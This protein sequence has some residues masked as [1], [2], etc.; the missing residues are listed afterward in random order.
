MELYIIR[1]GQSANNITMLRDPYDRGHY[2]PPL[3]DL[4]W[5]QAR[6]VADYVANHTNIDVW[7]ERPPEMREVMKG[8]GITRLYCSPMRRALETCLPISEALEMQPE[9]WVD[10]HEHGGIYL[11]DGDGGITG[12]SGL[13][14]AEM[15]AEFPQYI[16]PP[17]VSEQGWWNPQ[18][19]NEDNERCMA[20]AIRVARALRLQANSPQRLALVTHGTFADR[21]LKALFN[22]LPSHEIGFNHYNTGITRIDFRVDGKMLMRY[23]N[24]VEHLTAELMS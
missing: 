1:H 20:R 14:R 23:Q 8:F 11:E 18:D 10:I 7:I 19:K 5:R 12:Y 4:G 15:L 22:L 16:L 9:V 24:R 13:T 3:T 21:L 17:G 6:A 2:D